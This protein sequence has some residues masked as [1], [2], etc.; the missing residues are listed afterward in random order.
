MTSQLYVCT[1]DW[2]TSFDLL[3]G[4]QLGGQAVRGRLRQGEVGRGRAA[5]VPGPAGRRRAVE[6]AQLVVDAL[7]LLVLLLVLLRGQVPQHTVNGRHLPTEG[8]TVR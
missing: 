7:L 6:H 4:G 8:A 2:L 3:P 1:G 5:R